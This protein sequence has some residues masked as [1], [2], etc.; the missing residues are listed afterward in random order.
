MQDRSWEQYGKQDPYFGVCT[1]LKYK[2]GNLN[3]ESLH[4]FFTTGEDHIEEVL[5]KLKNYF[6]S[7]DI[8]S[9]KQVLDFGCGTGRLL[10]PLAHRFQNVTG[11]DISPGM[12]AEA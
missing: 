6:P 10:I 8:N 2:K 9:F 4:D 11:I 5:S 1:D 7:A 12:L 3:E